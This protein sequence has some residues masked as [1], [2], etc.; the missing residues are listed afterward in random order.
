MQTQKPQSNVTEKPEHGHDVMKDKR[1]VHTN[2]L[3]Y[4]ENYNNI[5]LTIRQWQWQ[6]IETLTAI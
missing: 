6:I 4:K 2:E 3:N 5:F 1:D